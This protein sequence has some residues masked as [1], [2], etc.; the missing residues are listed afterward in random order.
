M[1]SLVL[2]G[3]AGAARVSGA[4]GGS[5]SPGTAMFEEGRA[6]A[7]QGKYS[8]ACAKFQASWDQDPAVG[9]ELNLADCHEHLGHVAQAWQL[10]DDAAR[11][12]SDDRKRYARER[13]DGLEKRL[14]IA[15]VRLHD[16][17]AAGIEVTVAGH[18]V[19]PATEI[20]E[21]VEPGD[22]GVEVVVPGQPGFSEHKTV[23]VGASVE[24][25]VRQDTGAGIQELLLPSNPRKM[26]LRI[27]YS[28]G[29]VGIASFGLGVGLGLKARSDY[30]HELSNGDCTKNPTLVCNDAGFEKTHNA[31]TVATIGTVVGGVG[32][33]TLAAATVIY[34]TAP[35]DTTVAPI[36]TSQTVGVAISS[37]F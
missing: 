35:R 21:H 9:T 33:A 34:F 31:G 24:F 7:R 6:F 10:F 17:D 23:L 22:V 19:K 11:R 2:L 28:L 29:V 27:A 37:P 1:A 14:A 16:P 36:V 3:M 4:D 13:A 15:V 32:L 30:N 12:A 5:P 20:R 25:D 18:K 8:E 26:R